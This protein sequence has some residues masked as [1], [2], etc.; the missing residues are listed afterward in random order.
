MS[1]ALRQLGD[2]FDLQRGKTYKS[3][4][5]DQPGPLLLGLASIARNGGFRSD[6]LRTYGGESDD[7]ILV[8]PGDL[9]VS[10]KDVTQSADLLGSVA[11]FPSELGRGRLTQDTVKLVPKC[12]GV[13]LQFLYWTMRTPQYREYCRSRATGTTN[14][15]LARDDFLAY[16]VPEPTTERIALAAL[17]GALDDKIELNRKMGET[18]QA[19]VRAVLT[20]VTDDSASV[21][22]GSFGEIVGQVREGIDPTTL[23]PPVPYISLSDFTSKSFAIESWNSSSE[24]TSNK[25]VFE[26]RDI[27]FGKLRPYF[28][29]VVPAPVAGICSTDILVLRPL[30]ARYSS[31]AL[32]HASS[33]DL[34]AYATQTSTGTRMP[35][36][37]WKDISEFRIRIP[38]DQALDSFNELAGPAVERILLAV[39]ESHT[40]ATLRDALLPKL[41]SGEIRVPEAE[42]LVSDAT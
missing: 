28:H 29:K 37:N 4:L 9:Y 12:E 25:S 14:L 13:P 6:S 31:L 38:D 1:A 8:D 35:R 22:E 27:L 30:E 24:A 26:V 21:R 7:K 20:Q 3:A 41:I 33:D 11:C 18:I 36:T 39:K 42:E 40:L 15:G 5:L 16:P 34:I 23:D 32:F 19:L 2:F 10:L 17:L